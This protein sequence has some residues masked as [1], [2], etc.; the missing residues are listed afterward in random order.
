MYGGK[1]LRTVAKK[2]KD[3]GS[4]S[5]EIKF[6]YSTWAYQKGLGM[7]QLKEGVTFVLFNDKHVGHFENRFLSNFLAQTKNFI[8]EHD[9]T[10]ASLE[11]TLTEKEVE[12]KVKIKKESIK[13]KTIKI[14]KKLTNMFFT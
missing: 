12:Q 10:K 5:D 1:Y 14:F 11:K 6:V 13:N 4:D 8:K 7:K 9:T 2:V 3:I